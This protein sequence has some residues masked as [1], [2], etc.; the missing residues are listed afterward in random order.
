MTANQTAKGTPDVVMLAD[1][2]GPVGARQ[3]AAVPGAEVA[4]LALDLP[5]GLR[6]VRPRVT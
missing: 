5:G 3:V 1:G 4:C 6:I 2:S